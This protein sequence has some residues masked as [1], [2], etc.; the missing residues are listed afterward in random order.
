MRPYGNSVIRDAQQF[1]GRAE[2][3]LDEQFAER[4]AAALA[5]GVAG[6]RRAQAERGREF[7]QGHGASVMPLDELE[8]D[9]SPMR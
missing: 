6:A 1:G 2:A 3:G 8:D 9:G 4:A 5:D 7:G